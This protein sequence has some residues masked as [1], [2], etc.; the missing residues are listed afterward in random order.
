MWALMMAL[1]T[2]A[3]AQ[4]EFTDEDL[5]KYA[6]VMKWADGE[7]SKMS[8]EVSA[9]VN[10]NENLPG[11]TYKKLKAAY[12]A[13]DVTTADA[14]E[15]EVAEFM[16]ITEASDLLKANFKTTYTDKIKSDIGAGLYNKLKK[17]LK[18]DEVVKARYQAIFDSIE[19]PSEDA[20]D[21]E[22]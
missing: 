14:T 5:T 17:A 9:M 7:K 12:K 10:G 8:K 22:E 3:M 6:T 1:C 21:S 16:R 4:D 18:A 13:G 19:L 11:A 15:E 2:S 20:E